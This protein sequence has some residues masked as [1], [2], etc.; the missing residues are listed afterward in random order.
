MS[1]TK[2]VVDVEV[3]TFDTFSAF[4]TERGWSAQ[5]PVKT[6]SRIDV[7][8][9]G[10]HVAVGKVAVGGVAWAQHTGIAKVEVRVDNG[11][12][13]E[14]KLGS[15][16]TIDSWRQ[17]AYVW[18]APSGNHQLQVR[19]TDKSG[20]TQTSVQQGVIPNGATGYHTIDVTAS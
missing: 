4:W 5:G 13:A 20:Y 17:W 19:A 16:P 2:W 12:W 8:N 6:E 9:S 1:G 15:D 18:D 7:P 14:A 11:A 10:D 3:T